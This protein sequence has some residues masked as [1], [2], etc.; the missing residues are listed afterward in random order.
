MRRIHLK[1]VAALAGCVVAV[2]VLCAG[3]KPVKKQPPPPKAEETISDLAYLRVN[4]SIRVEGVGLVTHLDGTGSEAEPSEHRTKLLE[5]MRKHRIEHA[6]RWLSDPSTSLVVVKG[7]IPPG[8][9][10]KDHFD[11]EV[12][13]TPGSTTTSLEGGYL[14]LT[15]LRIVARVNGGTYEDFAV[16]KAGGPV[17]IGNSTDPTNPR[18]GRV[19]GGARVKKDIPYSLV[20]KEERKSGRTA[21]LIQ[22]AINHRFHQLKGIDQKG[23]SNAKSDQVIVLNVPKVYH[24]NQFRY[25]QVVEHLPVVENSTLRAQR[26]EKWGKE[27]LDPKTTGLAALRLEGIGRNATSLLLA[28]LE[29]PNAQ[30]RFFS[31]EALAYLN[32]PSGAEVLEKSVIELPQFRP[33]ALAALAAMD[34]PGSV[35]ALQRLMNQA[36]PKVRYG[37]FNALRTISEDD[38][39]L[40]RVPVLHDDTKDVEEDAEFAMLINAPPV[41]KNTPRPQ[42]P[43]ALYVVDCEGPP[44]IHVART[45]RCEIV[46][47]GRSQKLL[48]PAVLGGT[49]PILINASESDAKTV[50]VSKIAAGGPDDED[51]KVTCPA[52]LMDVIREAA[53]LGAS[54]PNILRILQDAQKRK[55]LPGPLIVDAVP[56]PAPAYDEAQLA[57][58]DATAKKDDAVGRTS[59]EKSERP[60]RGVLRRLFRPSGK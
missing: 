19:L 27:L 1:R 56:E 51:L 31:A 34:Q 26:L 6:E 54:Y 60:G 49:G 30:V 53:N 17:L 5:I 20:L 33:N 15:D 47:F 4:D 39:Y 52:T 7:S 44:L 41:R 8:I 43:F 40:G 37:A 13:L 10:T 59:L 23:M 36:E 22:A 3:S 35:L 2:A 24:H 16:A 55:N 46:I 57:G 9:S 58:V 25:F 48:T 12:E 28:G 50:E 45:R 14:I 21:A 42:D 29:S 18:V 11:V 32:E 38:P